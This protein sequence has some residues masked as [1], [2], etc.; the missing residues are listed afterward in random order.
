MGSDAIIV[1]AGTN[2][3]YPVEFSGKM[4]RK[5]AKVVI[6][7]SVPTGF[8]RMHYYKKE[9][10]L[11][12]SMSYGPGRLD[13]NYE[14]KGMDYPIGY[15]RWTENRNM[16]SYIDLLESKRLDVSKLISHTFSLEEAPK[17][18][19]MI[20]D[21]EKA[22]S[23]VLIQYNQDKKLI[24]K[25]DINN[26]VFKPDQVNVGLIGA[27][28]FAQGTLLPKM[29]GFCVT[30]WEFLLHEAIQQNMLVINILLII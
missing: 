15:V 17:A 27:G 28:S 25:V 12:M 11:R 14:D 10:E 5:K 30:L 7:G 2:S 19:E 9:L 6:V 23:G 13:T 22:F 20:L 8:S 18:Y 1:T 24:S 4:A 21:K 3:L 26:Q 16:K 29:K